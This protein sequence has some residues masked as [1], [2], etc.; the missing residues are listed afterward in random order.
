MPP[1]NLSELVVIFLRLIM[2]ALPVLFSL[3]TLIFVW[4]I[5]KFIAKSG[6]TKSHEEGKSLMIWGL[7]SLFV[8]LSFVGII[9]FAYRD[10]GFSRPFGIPV[11]PTGQ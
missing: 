10:I 11:L 6:D 2:L 1:S 3:A 4:G 8:M 5:V 9:R 7:I